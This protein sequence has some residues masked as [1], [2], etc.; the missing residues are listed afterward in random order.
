MLEVDT[1]AGTASS[2]AT[3]VLMTCTHALPLD[4]GL[5]VD[6]SLLQSPRS[7]CTDR[8][9]LS[10]QLSTTCSPTSEQNFLYG[11]RGSLAGRDLSLSIL[12]YQMQPPLGWMLLLLT[13]TFINS[14]IY[15]LVHLHAYTLAP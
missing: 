2:T 15:K 5:Q 9:T 3:S 11:P 8:Y 14:Y 12:L 1:G 4:S 7:T 13:D 10:H 6:S